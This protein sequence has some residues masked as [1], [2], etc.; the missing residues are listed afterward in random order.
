MLASAYIEVDILPVLVGFLA[1]ETAV[2]VRIHIAQ[3][4]G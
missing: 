1:Y 4:V 3:I 2:V